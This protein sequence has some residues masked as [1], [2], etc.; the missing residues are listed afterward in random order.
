MNERDANAPETSVLPRGVRRALDAMHTD[1][2]RD[3][4]LA[5]LAV[6]AGLSGRTLQRQF[7]M[8]LGKTPHEAL[9]DIRFEA[10]RRKL[11]RGAPG[12]KIMDVAARCGFPHFGRF[13]V[14]YRRRYGET[15]S[16]TLKRQAIFC[17][18]ASSRFQL[19]PGGSGRPS[20]TIGPI[21]AVAGEAAAARDIEHELSTALMRAGI[22]V[23]SRVTPARYHLAATIRETGP[24]R[25]LI[26]RLI[27]RDTGRHLWAHR[28]EAPFV[29]DFDEPLATRIAAAVHPALRTAEIERARTAPD[30]DLTAQDRALRAMPGV[31]SLDAQGNARALEL[32]DGALDRDPDHAL[33][34]ALAAWAHAQRVV[35]YFTSHPAEER[36][37]SA[38]LARRALRRP[39]DPTVLAIVGTALTLLHDIDAAEPV[40]AKALA[41]DGSSAWAWSRSG[42]IDA[43]T[44]NA[45]SAIE[46]FT[47]ALELAPNDPLAFNN[48]F[49]IGI[50][51]FHAGRHADAARWQARALAEHPSAAWIHRTM[52]PAYLLAG[53]KVEAS[54]SLDALRAAYPDLTL[55][56]VSAGLPPLPPAFRDRVV[57]G[58]HD[59]GLPS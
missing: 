25:R 11:L 41:I 33:S 12:L 37:R 50:A 53:A 52:C 17:G 14:E 23:S 2:G 35:Y 39:A 28:C 58:L 55:A 5:E 40:I 18:V 51:H 10:A 8:F 13:S 22:A 48:M 45:D 16:Q 32:L 9:C 44:G 7:R 57:E 34:A 20:L 46:R 59:A 15:P 29:G 4:G 36:V 38:E 3:I 43:Y 6:A 47:I 49:G 56:Q 19:P 27:D 26:F 1:L 21:E 30:A 54:R 31:L 24:H 42:W